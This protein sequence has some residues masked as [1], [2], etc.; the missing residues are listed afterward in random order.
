MNIYVDEAPIKAEACELGYVEMKS[1]KDTRIIF[2]HDA[3]AEAKKYWSVG[4]ASR[5]TLLDEHVELFHPDGVF[6]A[7]GARNVMLS[8]ISDD[9]ISVQSLNLTRGGTKVPIAGESFKESSDGEFYKQSTPTELT[10]NL[11]DTPSGL[12]RSMARQIL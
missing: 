10:Y 3:G 2:R 8:R 9:L 12:L 4:R 6:S 1:A 11:K 5:I 7:S